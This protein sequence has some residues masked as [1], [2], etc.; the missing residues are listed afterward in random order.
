MFCKKILSVLGS[1]GIRV[2][3]MELG[4][5]SRMGIVLGMILKD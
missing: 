4:R 1:V 2:A 5:N 3:E